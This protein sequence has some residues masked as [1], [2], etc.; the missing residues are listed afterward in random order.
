MKIMKF[1]LQNSIGEW[2]SVLLTILIHSKQTENSV[3]HGEMETVSNSDESNW[4]FVNHI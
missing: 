2:E 4:M 1:L 3:M